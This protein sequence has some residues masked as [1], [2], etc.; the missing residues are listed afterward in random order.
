[1]YKDWALSPEQGSPF[2]DFTEI[3]D[4]N[5]LGGILGADKFRD[6]EKVFGE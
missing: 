6:Q 3:F 2:R 5:F 1:M 4:I